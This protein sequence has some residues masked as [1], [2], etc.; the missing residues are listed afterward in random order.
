MPRRATSPQ[1]TKSP[2][3]SLFPNTPS[4]LTV[5]E[6]SP[7]GARKSPLQR[8]NTSPAALSP[9][10]PSFAPGPENESHQILI[11]PPTNLIGPSHPQYKCPSITDKVQKKEESKT[12]SD[13][14]TILP[15]PR[16]DSRKWSPDHSQLI[17]D[18]PVSGS[19]AESEEDIYDTSPMT[20]RAN[21]TTLVP[22]K[23]KFVEPQWEM[24][25]APHE[26]TH[27][28]STA[29]SSVSG[30]TSGSDH[31]ASASS[32]STSASSISAPTAPQNSSS[33]PKAII[34]SSPPPETRQRSATTTA[35]RQRRNPSEVS[36]ASIASSN[37][38]VTGAAANDDDENEA[39][40]KTAA[41]VSI[42]RQISV[43][44]QQRQL[45]IPIKTNS[46]KTKAPSNNTSSN[47]HN[48]NFPSP[49]N[50]HIGVNRVASPLGAVAVAAAEE[51]E[52]EG[53]SKDRSRS[54]SVEKKKDRGERLVEG[55]KPSTPTLVVVP[56]PEKNEV[57]KAWGGATASVGL[58]QRRK[59]SANTMGEIKV[60]LAVNNVP[61]HHRPKSE[62]VIV[63]SISVA[64]N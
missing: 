6:P 32:T 48:Q 3:F 60:G 4:R 47:K 61:H 50:G 16:K 45:L 20:M 33:V 5:R 41:D 52:R 49:L 58:A 23:P 14:S 40:L 29:S 38:S 21:D 44:R 62:K 59:G 24:V 63:E 46:P 57:M 12:T 51:R 13:S 42:A 26:Q 22:M 18:S 36:N 9:S 53:K 2:S 54:L 28:A 1:P 31:S 37:F 35:T 56:G 17:L 15:P 27:P 30:S 39:R 25:I 10:R 11:S 7:S 64:S 34:I 19:G 55:V 43:S 8:S